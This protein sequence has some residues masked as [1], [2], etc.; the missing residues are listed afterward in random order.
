MENKKTTFRLDT[1]EMQKLTVIME[2]HFGKN[3]KRMGLA[4]IRMLI[5]K[6]YKRITEK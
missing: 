4:A 6:E 2:H 3:V 1:E 5:E